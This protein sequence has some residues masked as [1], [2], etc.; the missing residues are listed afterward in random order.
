MILSTAAAL[1]SVVAGPALASI[2]ATTRGGG[3]RKDDDGDA[4]SPS[5]TPSPTKKTRTKLKGVPVPLDGPLADEIRNIFRLGCTGQ[6]GGI[7]PSPGMWNIDD[8]ETRH[9]RFKFHDPEYYNKNTILQK[10]K[11]FAAGII[12]EF[13]RAQ[14]KGGNAMGEI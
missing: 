9:P 10:L 11:S 2:G 3:K 5:S 13:N 14:R 12:Y 8:W 6:V 1:V 7:N 4:P